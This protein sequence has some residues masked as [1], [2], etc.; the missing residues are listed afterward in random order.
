[1]FHFHQAKR[2]FGQL[3]DVKMTRCII[4]DRPSRQTWNIDYCGP[5]CA[6]AGEMKLDLIAQGQNDPDVGW[7]AQGL[8]SQP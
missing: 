4:C 8:L 1:M 6:I 2:G 3:G 5:A 7:I